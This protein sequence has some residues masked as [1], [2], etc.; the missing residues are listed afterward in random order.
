MSVQDV[1]FDDTLRPTDLTLLF[2]RFAQ[3]SVSFTYF[4]DLGKSL[5]DAFVLFLEFS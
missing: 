2:Q 1:W 5:T 3:G 4:F